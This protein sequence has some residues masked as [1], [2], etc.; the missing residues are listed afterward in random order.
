MLTRSFVAVLCGALAVAALPGH[1]QYYP[2][3]GPEGDQWVARL[4]KPRPGTPKFPFPPRPA[5]DQPPPPPPPGAPPTHP[6]GAPPH[7]PKVDDKTIFQAL[8]ED[9]RCVFHGFDL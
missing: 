6:P 4:D 8:G 7:H 1:D 2:D 5:D 9:D 3:E